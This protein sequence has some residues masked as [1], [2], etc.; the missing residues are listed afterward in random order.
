MYSFKSRLKKTHFPVKV[1]VVMGK[2]SYKDNRD[3]RIIITNDLSLS[4]KEAVTT[5]FER[6]AIE[7]LFRELKDSFYFDHY[8]VRHKLKIMRYWMMVILTWSLIYWIK[9]N[10][11]LYRSISSSLKDHSIN[12]CKQVLLKLIIFS[13]YESLR[14]NGKFYADDFIKKRVKKNRKK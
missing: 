14:K 12:E 2:L 8:Q 13:S 4:C 10:G 7:R 5:Y 11:Y 1:F 6:W 9:Q 3:V